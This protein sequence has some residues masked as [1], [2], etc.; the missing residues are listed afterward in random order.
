MTTQKRRLLP[1]SF[2]GSVNK[3]HEPWHLLH[4]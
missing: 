3:E 4:R 2:G 1:K